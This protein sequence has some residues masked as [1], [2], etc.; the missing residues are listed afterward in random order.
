[1]V[2][3]AK[4]YIAVAALSSYLPETLLQEVLQDDRLAL[5]SLELEEHAAAEIEWLGSLST[6]VWQRMIAAL[7]ICLTPHELRAAVLKAAHT[8]HAYAEIKFMQTLRQLPWSLGRGDVIENLNNL[9][10]LPTAPEHTLAAQIWQ[11]GSL[12]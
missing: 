6:F 11:L 2:S 8:A 4:E 12:G 3:S 10:A 5:R 7:E 9:L 1:M